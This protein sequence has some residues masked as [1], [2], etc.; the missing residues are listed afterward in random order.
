MHRA[1]LVVTVNPFVVGCKKTVSFLSLFLFFPF[2]LGE[3]FSLS[4]L[5]SFLSPS[6]FAFSSLL[7]QSRI[8]IVRV[9]AH[10]AVL[11]SSFSRTFMSFFRKVRV[12]LAE[13]GALSRF[14]TRRRRDSTRRKKWSD[15]MMRKVLYSIL[16]F[17]GVNILIFSREK[18]NCATVLN[19]SHKNGQFQPL[20]GAHI[21]VWHLKC[22]WRV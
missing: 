2:F 14:V 7:R 20:E 15:R 22:A 18:N 12:L 16:L 17:L 11:S 21:A 6:L 1:G 9:H 3:C 5:P 4:C 8:D 13:G 10:C 19:R